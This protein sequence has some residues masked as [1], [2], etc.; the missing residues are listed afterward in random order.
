M[1]F[2]FIVVNVRQHYVDVIRNNTPLL[3][4]EV[5]PYAV[6]ITK[7]MQVP[8]IGLE[9][10]MKN[11]TRTFGVMLVGIGVGMLIYGFFQASLG[12]IAGL[13]GTVV[14]VIIIIG[15]HFIGH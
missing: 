1:A 12:L 6:T 5:K 2:R 14:A 7:R 9:V 4:Y 15:A 11:P 8:Y 10:N 3:V 13:I